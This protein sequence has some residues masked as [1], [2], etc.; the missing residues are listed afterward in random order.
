MHQVVQYC[1]GLLFVIKLVAG[2]FK[3]RDTHEL[4]SDG[5]NNLRKWPEKG[6]NTMK[7]MYKL[8]NFCCD[9]LEGVQKDCFNYSEI[10]PEDSDIHIDCLLDC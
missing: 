6:D 5:F 4:W 2:A 1:G 3:M 10:Y 9:Y 7:E 8:L